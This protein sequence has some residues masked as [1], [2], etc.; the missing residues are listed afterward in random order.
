[1]TNKSRDQLTAPS[2]HCKIELHEA[3]LN[4]VIGGAGKKGEKPRGLIRATP[5]GGG[6]PRTSPRT[7]TSD[8]ALDIL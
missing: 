6:L 8:R 2:D 4:R 1:M 7:R 5:Q 3:D